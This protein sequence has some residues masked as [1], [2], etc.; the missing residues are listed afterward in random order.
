M[1]ALPSLH[2]LRLCHRFGLGP[3]VHVNQ[4]PEELLQ[5]VEKSL[6]RSCRSSRHLPLH[7]NWKELFKC[8][9]QR[10]E[11]RFHCGLDPNSPFE[12]LVDAELCASCLED[13]V[14]DGNCENACSNS[15]GTD[16][17]TCTTRTTDTKPERCE[18]SCHFRLITSMNEAACDYD[19]G[20]REDHDEML[21]HWR[22][23]I[24]VKETSGFKEHQ[25]VGHACRWGS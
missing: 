3:D 5:H 25:T 1:H 17:R 8:F 10:C 14:W 19:W 20:W 22:Q 23:R 9:E 12:D 18:K 15:T 16:C 11:P 4:L 2:A 21:D 6:I 13:S 24:D 7:K